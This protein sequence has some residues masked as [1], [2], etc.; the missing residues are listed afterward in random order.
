MSRTSP[1][2]PWTST[3]QQLRPGEHPGWRPVVA[4]PALVVPAG[5]DAVVHEQGRRAHP[6]RRDSDADGD[7]VVVS[8][9]SL[10][11]PMSWAVLL[12][13]LGTQLLIHAGE[14][15]QR[16]RIAVLA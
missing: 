4:V 8:H 2:P 12:H 15:P 9:D 1:T 5:E 10:E 14:R 11:M 7:Y 13:P 3:P 6:A 16:R